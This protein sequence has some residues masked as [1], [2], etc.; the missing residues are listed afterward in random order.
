MPSL[1]KYTDPHGVIDYKYV[2]D[3]RDVRVTG[4]MDT[5]KGERD[6]DRYEEPVNKE[7]KLTS[8]WDDRAGDMLYTMHE[9]GDCKN[10][11]RR[12]LNE[13]YGDAEWAKRVAAH[14]NIDMPEES[15]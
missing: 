11:E 5:Y 15:K 1:Q 8:E 9:F 7:R 2:F 13:F 4:K 14:Y 6:M 3:G 12:L 10:G